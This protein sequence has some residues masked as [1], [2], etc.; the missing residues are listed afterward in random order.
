MA[1]AHLL[2]PETLELLTRTL[3]DLRDNI[4]LS[5][6]FWAVLLKHKVVTKQIVRDIKVRVYLFHHQV[7]TCIENVKFRA[8]NIFLL[9][10]TVKVE[11]QKRPPIRLR[12]VRPI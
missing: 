7:S 2:S 12:I 1:E 5:G 11:S 8:V 10:G 6:Y 4:K 3:P 9:P